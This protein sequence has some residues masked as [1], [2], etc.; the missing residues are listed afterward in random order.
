M[1]SMIKEELVHAMLRIRKVGMPSS[2][3][4]DIRMGELIVMKRLAEHPLCPD[5]DFHVSDI[6]SNLYMTKPALS[7]MLNVLEKKGY[8]SRRIDRSDRRK[9]SVALTPEGED[10]L[11]RAKE[12]MDRTMGTII[13][14][15]GE[16]NTRQ[17][18][19]LFTQLADIAEAVKHE[20]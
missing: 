5:R 20:T 6:H 7:Q 17:L 8:V 13:S 15:F 19:R 16:E 2:S 12:D 18:I 9:I 10:I 11:K 1:D 4:L 3:G 14:R